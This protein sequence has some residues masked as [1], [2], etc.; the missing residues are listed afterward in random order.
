[1]IKVIVK[2]VLTALLIPLFLCAALPAPSFS[3]EAPPGKPA[4]E[5]TGE[6]TSSKTNAEVNVTLNVPLSLS[7]FSPLPVAVVNNEPIT[8]GDMKEAIASAHAEKT[9]TQKAQGINFGEILKRLINMK[10][11][12]QEA[13][14]MGLD[15]MPEV[16][17]MVDVFARQT[18][19][20]QLLSQKTKDITPDKAEVEKIYKELA[21][22]W[23]IRSV[24]FEKEDDA[25]KMR[26]EIAGGK[27]FAVAAEE[28][29]K[30]KKAKGGEE[31]ALMKPKDFLP[32]IAEMVA[33]MKPG[34]V[35]PVI[36]VEPKKGEIG[37]AVLKLLEIQ[38]PEN[39][40][41]RAQ[42]EKQA[43]VRKGAETL[44]KFTQSLL[45][46]Y[47]KLNWAAIKSLDYEAPKPGIEKLLKEKRVLATVKGEQPI[48][49][50]DLT[51]ALMQ[52][53]YHGIKMA[54]EGKR[55]NENKVG[56]LLG[57]LEK[58]LLRKEALRLGI[59]KTEEYLK[60]V[61]EYKESVLFGAFIQ[62]AIIPDIKVTA[63]DIQTFYAENKTEFS[64]PE[65]IRM[66]NLVFSKREQA[67]D[68]IEKLRRGTDFNWLMSNSEGQVDRSDDTVLSFEGPL[69]TVTAL[70]DGVRKA[71]TG[72]NA[73]DVRYYGSPE[74]WH[75]VLLVQRVVPSKFEPLDAVKDGIVK[76][77][78]DR[79][80]MQSVEEWAKK[81][82][83]SGEVTVYLVSPS[84]I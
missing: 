5:G 84:G 63:E 79:K 2:T 59:G 56:V 65:M 82:R 29:V 70:P 22:E 77:A 66:R 81:L 14:T 23:K 62:K 34:A 15:D 42:A 76:K 47:G 21:Q 25:K 67:E 61:Q 19:R 36:K 41:A 10:L 73:G 27:D 69:L 58:A 39:P 71:V 83:E 32:Q 26:E 74:G 49:V 24:L 52:Q 53:Y 48:T 31:G 55:V 3:G 11:I 16:E 1:M 7:Q 28:A 8:L 68:S 4:R 35:S 33:K 80:L 50:A 30:G 18:L 64:S 51:R 20:D 54:S 44:K 13:K 9:D 72:A 75:Y 78:F 40:E 37:Y 43:N 60:A 12:I 38:Y 57:L 17:E 6:K 46:K 45:K